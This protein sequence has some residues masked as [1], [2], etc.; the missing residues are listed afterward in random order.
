MVRKNRLLQVL[1][2]LMLVTVALPILFNVFINRAYQSPPFGGSTP[3]P[4]TDPFV[5]QDG[6]QRI[7]DQFYSTLLNSAGSN[8]E[9]EGN[10]R[11]PQQ[12]LNLTNLMLSRQ[13]YLRTLAS[14]GGGTSL[15]EQIAFGFADMTNRL[16]FAEMGATE[17]RAEINK[18][19][20]EIRFLWGLIQKQQ[21]PQQQENEDAAKQLLDNNRS[22][23]PGQQGNNFSQ[24]KYVLSI[25]TK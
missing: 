25:Y 11:A 19:M 10:S 22:T 21:Q 13:S 24:G 16:R 2:T 3:D 23:L 15:E 20:K 18:L 12:Q 7:S 8:N 1:F 9:L 4:S 14:G 6:G 5:G 17:R